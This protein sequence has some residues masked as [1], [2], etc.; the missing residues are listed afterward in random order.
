[1]AEIIGSQSRQWSACSELECS[2]TMRKECISTVY[3]W[4]GSSVHARELRGPAVVSRG[5]FADLWMFPVKD[6]PKFYVSIS[7]KNH[8]FC[9]ISK[10]LNINL[11][12]LHL[13]ILLQIMLQTRDLAGTARKH[14]SF[15][16]IPDLKYLGFLW[17]MS[18]NLESEGGPLTQDSTHRILGGL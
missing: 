17:F 8:D 6:R 7:E 15:F 2:E 3:E 16:T 12:L 9:Q 5:S 18:W 4:V 11:T 1:M 10:T 13:K 14:S